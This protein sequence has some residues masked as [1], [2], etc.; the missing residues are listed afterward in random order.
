MVLAVSL[1]V[2]A[3][4]AWLSGFCRA[5]L[6]LLPSPRTPMT[7]ARGRSRDRGAPLLHWS[8]THACAGPCPGTGLAV[9]EMKMR[10]DGIAQRMETFVVFHQALPAPEGDQQRG[11]KD[12]GL[13]CMN[14]SR[15]RRTCDNPLAGDRHPAPLY[16][17]GFDSDRGRCWGYVSAGRAGALAVS[18]TGGGRRNLLLCWLFFFF[19]PPSSLDLNTSVPALHRA[20]GF[21]K[22]PFPPAWR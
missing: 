22:K 7:V 1:L 20:Q 12:W 19:P 4:I 3:L 13:L 6:Q 2:G 11:R 17:A 5:M 9:L 10:Q 18:V 8:L 16:R 21:S 14:P 15:G